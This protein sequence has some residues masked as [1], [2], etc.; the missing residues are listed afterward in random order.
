[1]AHVEH[2][3]FVAVTRADANGV[4]YLC[5]DC[6][7]WPGGSV[8]LTWKQWHALEA[9]AYGVVTSPGSIQDR[10]MDGLTAAE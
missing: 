4:T 9:D 1:V 3:H 5:S 2:D 7:P 8:D 6:G 10:A